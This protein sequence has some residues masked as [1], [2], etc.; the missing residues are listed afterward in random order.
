[1][2]RVGTATR[3]RYLAIYQISLIWGLRK[4]DEAIRIMQRAA[5]VPKD[6][7]IKY[8]DEVMLM[9]GYFTLI[10][11]SFAGFTCSSAPLQVIEIMVFL[12][13]LGRI[14]RIC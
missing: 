14:D 6:T 11:I 7:K 1:M 10:L 12:R 9:F 2:G 4:Y 3:V 8:H 5:F 13:R